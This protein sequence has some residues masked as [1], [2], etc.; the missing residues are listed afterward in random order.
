MGVVAYL[1]VLQVM[2][3][4][5]NPTFLPTLLLIGAATVPMAVLVAA[6]GPRDRPVVDAGSLAVAAIGGGIVGTVVAGFLEYETLRALSGL[7][8]L[9]VGLIEEAAKLIVP[10]ML[11]L[12]SKRTHHVT[13]GTAIGVASGAGFAVLETMGYGFNALLAD[14]SLAAVDGTLL[15]R[16]L[17]APAGHVAWTGMVCAAL[18]QWAGAR[19]VKDPQ[20]GRAGLVMLGTFAAAVALHALWDGVNSLVVHIAVI[21][22]SVGVLLWL[23]VRQRRPQG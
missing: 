19:S 4:T 2:V 11:L 3:T 23:V 5:S 15:L 12:L 20:T 7:Q 13:A 14:H 10:I 17:L 6:R 8:M 18:W 9:G 21:V 22:I 16:A 1:V